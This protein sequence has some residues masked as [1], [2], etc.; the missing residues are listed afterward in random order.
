MKKKPLPDKWQKSDKAIKAVQMAFD[1]DEKFQYCIRAA[2][3]KAGLSPSDQIRRILALP[4]VKRP[5]RPRLTVSLTPDDYQILGQKYGLDPGNQLEIKK[6]VMEDLI[7]FVR[8]HL[9]DEG[10]QPS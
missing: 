9:N 4:T 10:S 3:L 2:A 1:L 8:Q 5:K 7:A 6:R